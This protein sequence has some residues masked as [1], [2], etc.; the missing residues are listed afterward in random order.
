MVNPISSSKPQA[1]ITPLPLLPRGVWQQTFTHLPIEDLKA[2]ML[3]CQQF[4]ELA[5][6]ERDHRIPEI[7]QRLLSSET[8]KYTYVQA[9]ARCKIPRAWELN[10]YGFR[11]NYMLACDYRQVGFY[12]SRQADHV[13]VWNFEHNFST[14]FVK[15]SDLVKN[16]EYRGSYFLSQNDLVVYNTSGCFFHWEVVDQNLVFKSK[17]QFPK[18]EE[19]DTFRVTRD[20]D[21]LYCSKFNEKGKTIY[22][23]SLDQRQEDQLYGC[24][25]YT[26]ELTANLCVKRGSDSKEICKTELISELDVNE[27]QIKGRWLMLARKEENK[28]IYTFLDLIKGGCVSSFALP[29]DTTAEITL[30][31]G[32]FARIKL[33]DAT[34]K[35]K[36]FEEEAKGPKGMYSLWHVPTG[37]VVY[38]DARGDA[39]HF[40]VDKVEVRMTR[41]ELIS[42]QQKPDSMFSKPQTVNIEAKEPPTPPGAPVPLG[43]PVFPGAPALAPPGTQGFLARILN[44]LWD[45]WNWLN[46]WF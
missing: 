33:T 37:Q 30:C 10:N 12:L 20:G 31:S 43:A 16:S 28:R 19:G 7:F 44:V 23:F 45:F 35:P 32:G 21:M 11:N 25:L 46:S 5:I 6:A 38:H 4:S 2:V 1:E 14:D 41:P 27:V 39:L 24:L 3:V 18:L 17:Q 29:P 36:N 15:L 8:P 34:F 42:I 13:L 40:D 9:P 22:A 26:L